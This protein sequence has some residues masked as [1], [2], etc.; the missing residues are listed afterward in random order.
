MSFAWMINP[1]FKKIAERAIGKENGSV[2]DHS[3]GCILDHRQRRKEDHYTETLTFSKEQGE[4]SHSLPPHRAKKS[5]GDEFGNPLVCLAV[6]DTPR[7]GCRRRVAPT[8]IED[9]RV[10]H[11]R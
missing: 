2:Y 7:L 10:T 11:T 3:E 6:L 9:F 4:T 8:N 5:R 1:I